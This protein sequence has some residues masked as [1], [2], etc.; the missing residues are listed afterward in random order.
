MNFDE[1]NILGA[2]IDGTFLNEYGDYEESASF[3]II[4]KLV[5]EN[6]LQITCM[7]VVNL[8]NRTDMRKEADKAKDQL[9]KVCNEKLKEYKKQFKTQAGRALKT[10]ERDH[11]Y[12]VELINMSAYSPKGTALIRC[13]YNFEVT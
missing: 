11:D 5:N 2:I 1:T 4:S 3:K 7:S 13:I 6:T 9:A 12:N 8:L 10:K